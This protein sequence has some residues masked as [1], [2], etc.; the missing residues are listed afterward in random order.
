MRNHRWIYNE[1]GTL[2]TV[3]DNPLMEMDERSGYDKNDGMYLNTQFVAD[4]ALPWVK[5]LSL[6]T[7]LYYRVNSSHLKKL[8]ARAPQYGK[9]G[10]LL[11]VTKPSLKEEAYFGESYQFELSAAFLRTFADVHSI[12]AKF[13]FTAAENTGHN[14]WASRR[15][16]LSTTV[17]CRF[18]YDHAKCRKLGRRRT[19]G[20]GRTFEI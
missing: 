15:D 18:Q 20:I 2:S 17:V 6:G 11:D 12:D 19:N 7:M 9:D 16:Y 8:S 10:T 4:W 14:F 3:S 1:D 13:V 5:G